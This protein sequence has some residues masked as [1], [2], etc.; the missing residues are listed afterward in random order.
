MSKW[1]KIEELFPEPKRNDEEQARHWRGAL[2][3]GF[4]SPLTWKGD[5]YYESLEKPK[6]VTF[7]ICQLC[8]HIIW[9]WPHFEEEVPKAICTECAD[10]EEKYQND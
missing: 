5:K 6:S 2:F 7:P 8:H 9:E 10:E 3:W 1:P 4:S